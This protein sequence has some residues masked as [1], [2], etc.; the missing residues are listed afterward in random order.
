MTALYADVPDVGVGL[1]NAT[2]DT[3]MM[4]LVKHVHLTMQ[5]SPARFPPA[6]G[7]VSPTYPM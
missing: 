4:P 7:S 5:G 3:P 2:S 6:V 1:H